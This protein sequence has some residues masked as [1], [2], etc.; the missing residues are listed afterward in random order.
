M[1]PARRQ[2]LI[3]AL[4]IAVSA[5]VLAFIFHIVPFETVMDAARRLPLWLW[6]AGFVLFLAG[7][8]I[9]A[10]K[11][12]MLIGADVP[13]SVAFRAHLAGLGANL[14]LPGVAGGDVV[15]A[16]LVLRRT[17]DGGRLAIGSLADRLIDTLSLGLVALAGAWFA[18]QADGA[19]ALEVMAVILAIIGLTILF[20]RRFAAPLARIGM[21][22]AG[23][24]KIGRLLGK[25]GGALVDIGRQPG[26]L[27]GCLLLSLVTQCLF[28]AINI[29][30]ALALG[31]AIPAAAWFYS[32]AAAKIIAIAPISLGGLGVREASMATL[33]QPFGA[34]YGAV[35][36]VGLLWQTVLYASGLLGIVV[37]ST[38][39]SAPDR[40]DRSA[41][42]PQPNAGQI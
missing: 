4:R 15:R 34:D 37:Q 42:D 10:A 11:W 23:D 38:L 14:A 3:W 39:S 19:T 27:A 13:F 6:I 8:A 26:L 41:T 35:I 28:V 21:R 36:A 24:G 5:A 30:F 31:L 2:T 17:S 40:K 29:A 16:A 20:L 32:W 22:I 12:W 25:I 33:L 7:H 9:T 18:F 1:T